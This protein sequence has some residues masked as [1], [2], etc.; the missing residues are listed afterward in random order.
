M[1]RLQEGGAGGPLASNVAG[2]DPGIGVLYVIGAAGL[3]LGIQY[4]WAKY[5][6][7]QQ[8][9]GQ[10]GGEVAANQRIDGAKLGTCVS[11]KQN[12]TIFKRTT[13]LCPSLAARTN[14]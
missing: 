7:E 4:A 13:G 8:Y 6:Q 10:K 3:S 11:N 14:P 12:A 9:Y 5:Q 2:A 1:G